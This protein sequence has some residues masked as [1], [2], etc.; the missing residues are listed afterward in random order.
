[1]VIFNLFNTR[2]DHQ[3]QG[4]IKIKI[5]KFPNQKAKIYYERAIYLKWDVPKYGG[6]FKIFTYHL[7]SYTLRLICANVVCPIIT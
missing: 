3:N 7:N 2:A 4:K 1:M 6:W 5:I